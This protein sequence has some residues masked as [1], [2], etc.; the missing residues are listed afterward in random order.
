MNSRLEASED[1]GLSSVI[2]LQEELAREQDLTQDL[3]S[4]IQSLLE[5][6][7]SLSK[8]FGGGALNSTVG[9]S[10]EEKLFEALQEIKT[11][12]SKN[13]NPQDNG[14][15]FD[16]E[17]LISLENSLAEAEAAF[18][19]LEKELAKE[20]SLNQ[21]AKIDLKAVQSKLIRLETANSTNQDGTSITPELD[22]SL[23]KAGQTASFLSEEL[24]K[25][26]EANKQLLRSLELE[27]QKLA[28]FTTIEPAKQN[29]NFLN[30]QVIVDLEDTLADSE[31]KALALE[32]A[33]NDE[34]NK[35]QDLTN[36]IE[37]IRNGIANNDMLGS[38]GNTT[39]VSNSFSKISF[40]EKNL[41]NALEKLEV[42]EDQSSL[43]NGN[44]LEV[45]EELENSLNQAELTILDLQDKLSEQ[46]EINNVMVN[47]LAEA[48]KKLIQLSPAVNDL[49][50]SS[51]QAIVAAD[52]ELIE[53]EE[54]LLSAQMEVEML[55]KKNENESQEREELEK[56]LE[57][58][59]A[60]LESVDIGIAENNGT[61]ESL[62]L[63]ELKSEL[64]AKQNDIS[65]LEKQLNDA[66]DKLNDKETELEL[67]KAL[68]SMPGND[69]NNSLEV[70][71]LKLQLLDLQ[72]ELQQAY[73]DNNETGNF[74]ELAL[75][76][77]KLQQA[78]ADSFELQTEL[79]ETKNRLA[80]VAGAQTNNPLLRQ[81]FENLLSQSQTNE[82]KAIA[83]I[84]SLTQALKN[85]ESLRK[86]LESLIDEFQEVGDDSMDLANDPKIIKLQQEMLFLQEGLKQARNYDDPK[87]IEL[88]EQ[89]EFQTK[90]NESL[91]DE[92]KNAMKDFVR[93]K[94][95]V[96]MFEME[97][98]RLKNEAIADIKSGAEKELIGLRNEVAGLKDQ[99]SFLKLDLQGRDR[100][101]SDMRDQLIRSQNNAN[102]SSPQAN[103]SAELRGKIIRLE[104]DLQ[105]SRDSQLNQ[106]RIADRLNQE[107]AQS[108]DRIATLGKV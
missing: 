4:K 7:A 67:A 71:N 107:L 25:Q 15:N 19:S 53:M 37:A 3:Q 47:D 62:N 65:N 34:R 50:S 36:D 51:F 6:N 84:E 108:R 8:G 59:I 81:Q 92:F 95:Q 18:S 90:E 24:E 89:L 49:N 21:Q 100:R 42:L 80:E 5:K 58:A 102:F 1:G 94:N 97:N 85:S 66:I 33:L 46:I 9:N 98:E 20:K 105:A 28:S 26:K 74:G 10:L 96:E 104:G 99:N 93:L 14:I 69:S 70:E 30:N 91:N 38:D 23:S 55:K 82:Q 78:V 87:V 48:K 52:N 61:T 106:Q 56:K 88:E 76:K 73:A 54:A 83:E 2:L 12:H 68:S 32:K 86:E 16:P 103:D 101:L 60:K 77:E 43:N 64:V 44:G 79:E 57:N 27:K 35:N 17:M 29:M 40:L 75:M 13:A 39:F 72:K 41:V 22:S 11:L 45:V 31:S 63:L